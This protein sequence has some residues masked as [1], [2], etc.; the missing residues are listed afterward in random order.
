MNE[1]LNQ[2]VSVRAHRSRG[3]GE[4]ANKLLLS[5]SHSD[6]ASSDFSDKY[7]PLIYS[8][9]RELLESGL[10]AEVQ[11]KLHLLEEKHSLFA[12]LL[13]C[14]LLAWQYRFEDA[15][16]SLSGLEQHMEPG[17]LR[18]GIYLLV[19][20]CY[21]R[22][23]QLERSDDALSKQTIWDESLEHEIDLLRLKLA[24]QRKASAG[25]LLEDLSVITE[26]F[27][28]YAEAWAF[29][30][31]LKM[32]H[33]FE[34]WE[35]SLTI[36]PKQGEVYYNRGLLCVKNNDYQ[37]ATREFS[38][39]VEINPW[40]DDALIQLV[41]MLA[42][43][44]RRTEAWRKAAKSYQFF[45]TPA[46]AT[47]KLEM[48]RKA[49][50]SRAT[51]WRTCEELQQTHPLSPDVSLAA[52]ACWQAINE[53]ERAEL[54]YKACLTIRPGDIGAKANLGKVLYDRGRVHEA[55]SSW[56]E[57][58]EDVPL[59]V[60]RN[61]A[62]ALLDTGRREEALIEINEILR[63]HPNDALALCGRAEINLVLG[64]LDRV[65]IDL[66]KAMELPHAPTR[67][68]ILRFSYTLRTE[69]WLK[70]EAV[71][72]DGIR[73]AVEPLALHKKL[74]EEWAKRDLIAK[75]LDTIERW[76]RAYPKEA[77]YL[78]MLAEVAY[79]QAN[80]EKALDYTAEAD[81]LDWSKA[82][83]TRF[84]ILIK[85]GRYKLAQRYAEGLLRKAPNQ[86]ALKGLVAEASARQGNYDYATRVLLG[87]IESNPGNIELARQLISVY[88]TQGDVKAA[89]DYADSLSTRNSDERL[90]KLA[91][92]V[93]KE[94]ARPKLAIDLCRAMTLG[95]SQSSY[96]VIELALALTHVGRSEEA[97]AIL[98][99]VQLRDSKNL[100]IT[101]A[102]TSALQAAERYDEAMEVLLNQL[103]SDDSPQSVYEIGSVLL[104]SGKAQE[105]ID[106]ASRFLTTY[107]KEL[108]LYR[109]IA[110]AL[111]RLER[112]D[113][114][115]KLASEVTAQLP[116]QRI[117]SF[118]LEISIRTRNPQA[119][120][121]HFEAWRSN[122]PDS[123]E[124]LWALLEFKKNFE[125]DKS[126]L[127]VLKAIE[128]R[129]PYSPRLIRE[130]IVYSS[131]ANRS[132]TA[133]QLAKMLCEIRPADPSNWD[134]LLNE[135]M[136]AGDFSAFDETF[137]RIE[138]EY[139]KDRFKNYAKYFFNLNC[140]PNWSAQKIYSYY[141]NW[142]VNYIAPK[143]STKRPHKNSRETH[144]RLRIGYV[145]PDFCT[146]PVARF[147]EPILRY[148]P[149]DEFDIV[150]YSQVPP[151]KTD[152]VTKRFKSYVD[153]WVDTTTWADEEVYRDVREREI[154]ILVD[155]AGHTGGSRLPV[156]LRKPAPVQISFAFG[157]GQTTGISEIDYLFT[158][159]FSVP[160]G[161]EKCF[162]ESV[163]R[164]DAP[165]FPYL[166]PSDIPLPSQLDFTHQRPIRFGV[167]ARPL[168]TNDRCIS[169][170][171]AILKSVPLSVIVFDHIPYTDPYIQTRFRSEFERQGVSQDRLIFQSTRPHWAA[172][173]GI[174]I[175]L[176]TFPSGSGTVTTECIYME[177]VVVTLSS[178]PLMGLM[179]AAQLTAL[180]LQDYLVGLD[181]DDYVSKAVAL[182]TD[183]SLLLD[184]SKG[185]RRRFYESSLADYE[186]YT[187]EISKTY[188][189]I[190]IKWCNLPS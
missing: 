113:E 83:S 184:L 60:K 91:L 109:L 102:L 122:E 159:K 11:G 101:Q 85:T 67:A 145:S 134:L 178:R 129:S 16:A 47:S 148:H 35:H 166:P 40:F 110:N 172:I 165:G 160:Q 58:G 143:L 161:Y 18:Q 164:L 140:H 59:E 34:Y 5:F 97:V 45:K 14:H 176:D 25:K 150:A 30:A 89:L 71:L 185:L 132:S 156:F 155:L 32:D 152:D 120:Q 106:L 49:G 51:I 149:R 9:C 87:A 20:K 90:P 84:R 142:Y 78:L 3:D 158:D 94:C 26:R 112:Y 128:D 19:A 117:A 82:A 187:R 29:R 86:V 39:S 54:A 177:R 111:Y 131:K 103:N 137:K 31:L 175:L 186:G 42:T 170:W 144:R 73:A 124:P 153:D 37:R 92:S 163:L 52:G 22:L 93:Y 74:Y 157:A 182:A 80:N 125:D 13:R 57:I 23:G 180:G 146:H 88:F 189:D 167:L 114:M 24:W 139:G 105:A 127:P 56:R 38:T 76:H 135:Q 141:R 96:W 61:L 50:Q 136:K 27:P 1:L 28:W 162:A 36:Q 44:G 174:D 10:H 75:N 130:Q 55:I 154:D 151:A 169:C 173:S 8:L 104:R 116:I 98:K 107:P 179:P 46:R 168:R 6:L 7:L 100:F 65:G 126:L 62:F 69:G 70:A 43:L 63:A 119:C 66:K 190:W 4:E 115:I 147:A 17:P 77:D 171:A 53:L 64:N 41:Q 81:K 95:R 48:V 2:L 188:R 133:I 15:V 181:E 123:V 118:L 121:Q 12:T 99:D 108:S 33:A 79:T 138:L 183:R 68:W 21:Q 72:V